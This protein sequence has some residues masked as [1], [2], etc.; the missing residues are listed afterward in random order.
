MKPQYMFGL[1]TVTVC[2]AD[3]SN[4]HLQCNDMIS[5]LN[6]RSPCDIP[7][8]CPSEG[9]H[10]IEQ[11]VSSDQICHHSTC[12][13]KSVLSTLTQHMINPFDCQNSA[14]STGVMIFESQAHLWNPV[15]QVGNPH[16]LELYGIVSVNRDNVVCPFAYFHENTMQVLNMAI[17]TLK[18]SYIPSQSLMILAPTLL[19]QHFHKSPACTTSEWHAL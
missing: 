19:T 17:T 13:F 2:L 9:G 14:M 8:G 18:Q 16:W 7:Y 11:T 6:C 4:V 1:S 10:N 12:L 15:V 3:L 5:A